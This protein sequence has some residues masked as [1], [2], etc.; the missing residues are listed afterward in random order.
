MSSYALHYYQPSFRDGLFS[1]WWIGLEHYASLRKRGYQGPLIYDEPG[2]GL[3]NI[4]VQ[5]DNGL[6]HKLVYNWHPSDKIWSH[7]SASA[8]ESEEFQQHMKELHEFYKEA[9][10]LKPEFEKLCVLPEWNGPTYAVALRFPGHYHTN[11]SSHNPLFKTQEDLINV[12]IDFLSK[13]VPSNA[14]ILVL[15]TMQP[16][17]DR[18]VELFTLE[19]LIIPNIPRS[20][21]GEDWS[22]V[23][24]YG[25]QAINQMECSAYW[26]VYMMSKCDRAFFGP[27]NMG[28][29]ARIMNPE[30]NFTIYP[31]LKDCFGG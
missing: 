7:Q 28:V 16:F 27:S 5:D 31:F 24:T 15:S 29:A 23:R 18:L 20:H 3:Q 1:R 22:F 4:L 25:Q 2:K 10:S 11:G 9:I 6:P 8:L 21:N 30:L 14:R 19:R 17:V 13:E 12:T 26:E